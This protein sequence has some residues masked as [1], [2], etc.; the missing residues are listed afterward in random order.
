MKEC[1][2]LKN[3]KPWQS[4]APS[5]DLTP[6]AV[7]NTLNTQVQL[8]VVQFSSERG[9]NPPKTLLLLSCPGF[10]LLPLWLSCLEAGK[11]VRGRGKK[12]CFSGLHIAMVIYASGYLRELQ[13]AAITDLGSSSWFSR[14]RELPLEMVKAAKHCLSWSICSCYRSPKV[15]LKIGYFKI[16][17]SISWSVVK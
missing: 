13:R 15:L 14:G 4:L 5:L 1:I 2:S 9:Q 16:F 10:P 12:Q 11:A 8:C 3:C 17:I 7:F 6:A